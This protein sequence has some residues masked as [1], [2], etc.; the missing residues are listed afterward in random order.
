MTHRIGNALV[1][2]SALAAVGLAIR[3]NTHLLASSSAHFALD[4]ERCFGVARAG[5]NDCGTALH[6][7]AG[8]AR[9]DA[10]ADEWLMLPAGTCTRIAGGS[11]KSAAS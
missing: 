2:A 8:R 11:L 4:R 5:K 3:Q 6:A 10:A 9:Y 1:I 7:C